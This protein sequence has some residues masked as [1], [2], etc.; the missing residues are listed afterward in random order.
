VKKKRAVSGSGAAGVA[1]HSL[2]MGLA[3]VCRSPGSSGG[4]RT[5]KAIARYQTTR[6]D[7]L[8]DLPD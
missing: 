5:S 6:L 2:R 3:L 4:D 7:D 8:A 1:F